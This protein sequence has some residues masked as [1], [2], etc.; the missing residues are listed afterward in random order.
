MAAVPEYYDSSGASIKID[1]DAVYQSATVTMPALGAE[2]SDSVSRVVQIWN[3]LKLGWVG[4]TAQEAQDFN[5]RW[6]ASIGQL[7][8]A[9]GDPSTGIL[10]KITAGVAMAGVNYG[11]AEDVVTNMFNQTSDALIWGSGSSGSSDSG[12]P[13]HRAVNGG[14]VTEN[15]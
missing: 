6:S 13:G 15:G 1:P 14:S 12:S 10:S 5:D 8:G 2:I 3:D 11:Q 4:N 7:F 9:A